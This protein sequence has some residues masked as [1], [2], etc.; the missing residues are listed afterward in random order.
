M[1]VRDM[2][3][4]N[5]TMDQHECQVEAELRFRARIGGVNP[6]PSFWIGY[7]LAGGSTAADFRNACMTARGWRNA[8]SEAP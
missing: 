7:Y 5:L 8:T 2:G 6:S 1:W 4:S 3:A